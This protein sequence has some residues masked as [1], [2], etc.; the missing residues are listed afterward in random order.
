[1]EMKIPAGHLPALFKV[2]LGLCKT[3]AP[4]TPFF[5]ESKY[6][7]LRLC[8]ANKGGLE[9]SIHF[10][11]FPE[12]AAKT[13]DKRVE[14]SVARMQAVIETGRQIRERNNKPLK[15]PLRR[16]IV[17]HDSRDFLTDLQG[18]L[19]DYVVNELNVRELEVCEDLLKY[20]SVKAEPNFATLG[21]RLGKSMGAVSKGIKE[22]SRDDII[23]FQET[24]IFSVGDH[25]LSA[26]DIV[27][28]R[29]FCLPEGYTKQEMDAAHRR[30]RGDG[31][32]GIDS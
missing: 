7:N 21:K 15:T 31:D 32:N 6:Q 27:V 11:R 29:E 5:V 10:W 3:R 18:E 22:M 26:T 13:L 12:A 25:A 8:L 24:G 19:R 4:F 20:S 1:M 23:S 2:L 28:K 9:P 14:S 16:M 17:A 30:N